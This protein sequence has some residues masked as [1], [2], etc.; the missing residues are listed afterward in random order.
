MPM[1]IQTLESNLRVLPSRTPKRREEERPMHVCA[2]VEWC[3]DPPQHQQ[4]CVPQHC[5]CQKLCLE[6]LLSQAFQAWIHHCCLGRELEEGHDLLTEEL[7]G[8]GD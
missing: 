6:L 2:H 3:K 5:Q 1:L 4:P 8:V 7:D